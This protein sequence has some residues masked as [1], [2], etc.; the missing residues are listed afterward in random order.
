MPR[1]KPPPNKDE[2][3]PVVDTSEPVG[4][5][6]IELPDDGAGPVEIDLSAGPPEAEPKPKKV[7]RED[8]P[9]AKALAD[10]QR[11][12]E[13][14]RTAQRERDEALARERERAAELER[15]RERGDDAQYTSVLTAIAAEQ[16]VVAKA[17]QDY[18][19]HAQ[20]GDWAAAAAAQRIMAAASAR[21]DRLEDGKQS[22][23]TKR[24]NKPPPRAA[25]PAVSQQPQS[26]EEKI[27]VLPEPARN[28]LRN[29]P[30]FIN[31]TAMNRKI[32]A[33]HQYLTETKGVAQFSSAY[34]EALN[35][36]FGFKT[37]SQV[38][39]P[40]RRTMPMSAPVSRDVPT[41]TGTRST[42]MHLTE[43]ERK[44]AR[45][46]IMDRPD[47]PNLTNEQKEYIYAQNKRKLH[48]MRANGQYRQ[49]TEQT[50]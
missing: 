43:E 21:L 7:D 30:E 5:V 23:E 32:N 6:Q 12:E 17:E 20:A 37:E 1:L 2:L 15:E 8:S 45:I 11:A 42:P 33:A 46:S 49:T 14:Q 9:L 16:S 39:Q 19:A 13:M 34:F 35:Q 29:H 24:E 25:A 41:A 31:D 40:Q 27:S 38:T 22:F 50:G 18:A 36:E 26:F 48:T 44:I 28:W 10:Q 47:M 3:P 4:D